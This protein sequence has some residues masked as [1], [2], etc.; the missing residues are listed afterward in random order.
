[1]SQGPTCQVYPV[2]RDRNRSCAPISVGAIDPVGITNASTTNPRN[3]NAS[4]NAMITEMIVSWI[5]SLV[6]RPATGPCPLPVGADAGAAPPGGRAPGLAGVVCETG[7]A[8]FG[9]DA[10]FGPVV[11]LIPAGLRRP[12]VPPAPPARPHGA[13]IRST[14]PRSA[15]RTSSQIDP[16]PRRLR[17]V[18]FSVNR[19]ASSASG[20]PG[21]GMCHIR[22]FRRLVE[23]QLHDLPLHHRPAGID[24]H[25]RPFRRLLALHEPHG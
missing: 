4:A 20:E 5:D 9:E 8:G 1:M 12:V 6:V 22:L 24:R 10:G 11:L 13:I 3:T 16:L 17:S 15:S 19:L 25:L 7:P 18:F 21:S 14:A 23:R 2:S